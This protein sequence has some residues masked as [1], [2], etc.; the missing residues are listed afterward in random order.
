MDT[1]DMQTDTRWWSFNMDDTNL[2][3]LQRSIETGQLVALVDEEAG[4]IVGYIL[5]AHEDRIVNGL[6]AE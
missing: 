1:F 2:K 3:D 4:G 5:A 6:N